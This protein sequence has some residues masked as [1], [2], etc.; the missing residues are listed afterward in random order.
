MYFP[1]MKAKSEEVNALIKTLCEVPKC[2]NVI[3][4]IEASSGSEEENSMYSG[5][6]KLIS[7][8]IANKRRFICLVDQ[9]NDLNDIKAEYSED[10]FY[11][12]CIY[13]FTNNFPQNYRFKRGA[14]IHE[15]PIILK[16]NSKI[17]YHIFMPSVLQS[18]IFYPQKYPK[19]KLVYISDAFNKYPTNA[20]Y[21]QIDTFNNC[22]LC[23]R[24]KEMGIC[25]FGDFTILEGNAKNAN[26]GD[27]KTITHVIHLTKEDINNA[28]NNIIV[29]NHFL[30]TPLQEA[31]ISERSIKTIV[32]AYQK[33][34]EFIPSKGMEIVDS[35]YNNQR[36]TSLGMYKRIGIS[37]HIC[38]MNEIVERIK[39]R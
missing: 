39:T 6:K 26:G 30:T 20:D 36:P 16:D 4:I 13:G 14:V 25:G 37:H 35:Y 1:Y 24:Y 21:P 19:E 10:D 7:N 34:N 29:T 38:L 2:E 23:Y 32:K 3:P 18:D 15:E 27:Q 22:Q 33:K 28:G 31:D 5:I 12:Y 8:L 17:N 11:E 9:E